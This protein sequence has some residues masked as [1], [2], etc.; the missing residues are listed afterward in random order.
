VH[1]D[2]ARMQQRVTVL[3]ELV[4]DSLYAPDEF[5]VAQAIIAR[6]SVRR[7]VAAPSFRSEERQFPIR[8]FR[9]DRGARS[10]RL[11]TSAAH[12]R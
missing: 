2:T 3:R 1:A 4:R 10:F 5:E 9:R 7:S 12:H 8:S 6:A 11:S